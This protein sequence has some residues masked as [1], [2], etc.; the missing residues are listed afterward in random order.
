MAR[1]QRGF[2]SARPWL[3][4]VPH[5][6]PTTRPRFLALGHISRAPHL[7]PS[8]ACP[9]GIA[10]APMRH[11]LS[12]SPGLSRAIF[13]FGLFKALELLVYLLSPPRAI[14]HHPFPLSPSESMKKAQALVRLSH[15]R[16]ILAAPVLLF[17]LY[18]RHIMF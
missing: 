10:R 1:V 16:S 15:C 9:L 11:A 6:Q 18:L 7:P 2:T 13:A 17:P 8:I 4:S 5:L 12:A 3:C 14:H